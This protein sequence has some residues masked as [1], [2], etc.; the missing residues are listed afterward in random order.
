MCTHN[1]NGHS[2]PYLGY[3]ICLLRQGANILYICILYLYE[4]LL[5]IL[6]CDT[7]MNNYLLTYCARGSD[8]SGE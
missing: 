6:A 4:I 5:V 3:L 7:Y 8:V 1:A 2:L